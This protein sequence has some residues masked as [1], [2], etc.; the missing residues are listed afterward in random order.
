VIQKYVRELRAFS[1]ETAIHKMTLLPATRFGLLDRGLLR[2]NMMADV[3][4]FDPEKF[5]TRAT[6]SDPFV[7]AEGME[8]VFINGQKALDRGIPTGLLT[9]RVLGH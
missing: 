9:G 8:Y 2:E 6:Y 5:V 3:I 1:L 4:V 7:Y